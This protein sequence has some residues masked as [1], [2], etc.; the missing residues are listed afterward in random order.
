MELPG[1]THTAQTFSEGGAMV[2][3]DVVMRRLIVA[4]LVF[5]VAVWAEII[6]GL[7]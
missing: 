1:N 3:F 4:G 2:L 7:L 6:G 5:N